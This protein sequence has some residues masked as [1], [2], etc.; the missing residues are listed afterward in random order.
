MTLLYHQQAIDCSIFFIMLS[1]L[2]KDH[3]QM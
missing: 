3:L 2:L 1:M